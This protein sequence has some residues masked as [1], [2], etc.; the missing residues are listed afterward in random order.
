MH[1]QK[2]N[3]SDVVLST[4]DEGEEICGTISPFDKSLINKSKPWCRHE[5]GSGDF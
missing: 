5:Q 1:T 2:F 4:P 3:T